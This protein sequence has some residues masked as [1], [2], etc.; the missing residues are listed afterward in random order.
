MYR[1]KERRVE[2]EFKNQDLTIENVNNIFDYG[3]K[4]QCLCAMNVKGG[5]VLITVDKYLASPELKPDGLVIYNNIL[6]EI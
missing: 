1:N 4:F 6:S 2:N 3:S 5:K